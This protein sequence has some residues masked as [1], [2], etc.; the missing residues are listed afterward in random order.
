[1]EINLLLIVTISV[2]IACNVVIGYVLY[3]KQKQVK[4]LSLQLQKLKD[5][6]TKFRDM[7][8]QREDVFYKNLHNVSISFLSNVSESC[9]IYFDGEI[10]RIVS[11]IG[12]R[13]RE[14]I[15]D[16]RVIK[17]ELP[18]SASRV[19]VI[20]STE[21][22]SISLVPSQDKGVDKKD[23]RRDSKVLISDIH[24]GGELK[25]KLLIERDEPFVDEEIEMIK[26]L[27]GFFTSFIATHNYV[28]TQGRFEK[29]MILTM[30]RILEYHDLYTKGHSKNVATI[31][32]L[33]AEKLGLDDEIIKKTYWAGIGSRCW[34]DC[35]PIVYLEQR[36]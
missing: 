19:Y 18:Y 24:V 7:V 15:L 14:K 23:P 26:S 2:S 32:S 30:I 12:D 35:N 25:A 8:V 34:K 33:I 9:L 1:M 31:A 17:T 28:T 27:S 22:S 20:D 29:D 16:K 4:K 3:K 36:K 11:Y 10:G 6:S 13:N 5:L 21:L